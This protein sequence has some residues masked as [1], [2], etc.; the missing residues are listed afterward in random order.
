MK[1]TAAIILSLILL[2]PCSALATED[3]SVNAPCAVLMEESTGTI[4]YAKGENEER[5]PASVTKVM[6]L[7]LIAEAVDSGAIS[8]DDTVTATARAASMGGSQIWLEAGE[9]MSVSEMIKCVAV[10]SANDCAVALA[11]HLCGSEE[12]FI[13]RMNERAAELGLQHT[14]FTNCTGLF[15][16]PEHYTSALDIAVMSRELLSH[17][18]IKD[19]TTIWMDSI[20]NGEF[21]L[22]S[23][24]HLLRSL[25]GCTG[26]KT[27]WTTLAGYC[28]SASAE[29]EGTE[30]I[31]VIM[32][33]DSSANRNAD[34]S[35]LINYAFTN[36]ALVPVAD[37]ALP[38]VLV[39]GGVRASVQPVIEGSDHILL[40]RSEAS[41][42]ERNVSLPESVAAPI[43]A[44]ERLGSLTLS[45]SG[46]TLVEVPLVSS[47]AVEKLGAGG[48]LL[49]LFR[50]LFCLPAFPT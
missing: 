11:E 40:R 27:G 26:L 36:W 35:T 17:E 7:L 22:S 30:Y 19:Y 24:N 23:T 37:S 4:L 9:Q 42:L 20:R 50:Q 14:N 25:E 47:E 41:A 3:I 33:S 1:R 5:A 28:I 13:A 10:V 46:E 48:V 45:S 29:R 16:D 31:A 43:G 12:V 49:S 8:L 32:G 18:W 39:S 6:T 2:A 15:D 21:G 44:G 38:P 34:A